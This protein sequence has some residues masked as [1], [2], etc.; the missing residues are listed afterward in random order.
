MKDK[1]FPCTF[2]HFP[3]FL[4]LSNAVS[5]ILLKFTQQLIVSELIHNKY[6][7]SITYALMEKSFV[8]FIQ[9]IYFTAKVFK[10]VYP[11]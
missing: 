4:P 10:H 8:T 7:Q 5:I 2:S 6:Q 1:R 11:R 3:V 9:E